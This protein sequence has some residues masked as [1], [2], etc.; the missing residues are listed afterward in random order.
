MKIT[1]ETYWNFI[2]DAPFDEYTV[3]FLEAAAYDAEAV[4]AC[5]ASANTC[6]ST[7]LAKSLELFNNMGQELTAEEKQAQAMATA[8]SGWI[9]LG[10]S[11]YQLANKKINEALSINP[12]FSAAQQAKLL[13]MAYLAS[14]LSDDFAEASKVLVDQNDKIS[15]EDRELWRF[16]LMCRA[17]RAK[18]SGLNVS[19]LSDSAMLTLARL[20]GEAPFPEDID[21]A[22]AGLRRYTLDKNCKASLLFLECILGQNRIGKL[23]STILG[24]YAG[25]DPD[26]YSWALEIFGSAAHRR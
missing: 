20:F 5:S 8:D 17:Q 21:Q 2:H 4:S 14:L 12:G 9:A 6:T 15:E 26:I 7:E 24:C 23:Q 1:F 25:P 11:D 22:I 18:L 19:K 10:H 13:T 3:H 16:V